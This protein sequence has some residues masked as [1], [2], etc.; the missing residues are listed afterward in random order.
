MKVKLLT[1]VIAASLSIAAFANT[2][3]SSSSSS[4]TNSSSSTTVTAKQKKELNKLQAQLVQLQGE[5]NTIANSPKLAMMAQQTDRRVMSDT[6]NPFGMMPDTTFSSVLLQA[7]ESLNAPLVMGGYL[8]ADAQAW[9]GSLSFPTSSTTYHNGNSIYLTTA[10]LYTL[11]NVNDWTSVFLSLQ[12]NTNNIVSTT[13]DQAF[14]TFGDLKKYPLY[15]MVGKGYLPFGSFAGNGIWSNSITTNDFRMSQA[16]QV[17]L[18]FY[19]NGLTLNI[20]ATNDGG[21]GQ[22]TT[23]PGNL[24]VFVY[25]ANYASSF[26]KNFSYSIGASYMNDIRGTE[27]G[28]GEAYNT[29]GGTLT[30]GSNGAYDF[31][32]SLGYKTV[33]FN[34]EYASTAKSATYNGASTGKIS[35]WMTTLNYAPMLY[36]ETTTFSLGYSASNNAADVPY[37]VSAMVNNSPATPAGQGFKNEWIAFAQRPIY[38]NIYIGPEFDYAKTYA[39]N[40]TWTGTF[41]LSAFF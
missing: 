24:A 31:N 25:N 3:T 20:A 33:S 2:S 32:G 29:T 26:A 23:I 15:I 36:G 7:K 28:V 21:S 9:G 37:G 30:G 16:N 39:G 34:A 41:D 14:L 10:K 8:E 19:Q 17:N 12:G 13:F 27:A 22:V 6:T 11:G 5:V 4:T 40:N 1:G 18:G 38:N 35:S